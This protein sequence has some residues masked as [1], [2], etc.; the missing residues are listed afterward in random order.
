MYDEAAL[1][2]YDWNSS[3]ASSI[4]KAEPQGIPKDKGFLFNGAEGIK[5]PQNSG[6]DIFTTKILYH[7]AYL[8]T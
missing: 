2:K 4:K 5:F 7:T 3:N 8:S 1:T 6:K